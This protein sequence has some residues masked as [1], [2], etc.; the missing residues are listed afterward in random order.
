MEALVKTL[1]ELGS[2]RVMLVGD[3]MLDSWIYG[4]AERLSPEAPVPVL[5]KV[6]QETMTG[7]ASNIAPAITALGGEVVCVGVI[8][9]DPGGEELSSLLMSAGADASRLIR[10]SD[11]P[12]TVKTRYIGLAQHRHAQQ[13]FRLD[14]ESVEEFGPDVHEMLR[15][16]VR[17]EL[18][19]CE[20]LAIEDYNKGVLGHITTPQI[21]DEAR[22]AGVP[23]I[24]D[25]AL[26]SDYR[27][28][29]GANLLTPNR[30]EAALAS[31]I[32]ITDRE[33][34]LKAAERIAAITRAQAVVITL[35]AEGAFLYTVDGK[36]M[37][38]P[39]RARS[40]YDVSGA[41]DEVLA[42]LAVAIG[43]GCDLDIAV[44]LA[45]VAGGLEV[46]QF[47]IIPITRAQVIDELRKMIGLRTRKVI[48]RKVLA[49]EVSRRR[50]GGENI[51]FTNGC[52]DLLHVGHVRY[53]QQ[54]REQ[55]SCLV[56]AIN[57]DNS[58]RRLKG[59]DRPII[60]A[61]ERAEMLGALECVDYVTVF[62]EDTPEALLKLL[63]PEILIKGGSTPVVVGREIVEGY[64]G[65]VQTL[66][67]V[68]GMSTTNIIDR[69]VNGQG[70]A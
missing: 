52:F 19:S 32:E 29:A 25:P 26:I 37:V 53:L 16:A 14:E 44:G 8:G 33:S 15:A 43:D 59:P 60:G 35:D 12:T 28:Y 69:I 22:K 65:V 39:T 46:E 56:V 49:A 13:M 23:V 10:R 27:R 66:Q 18:H 24:V 17:S 50:K 45:N 47:G 38:I 3:F 55:G 34:M 9:D 36:S 62:D 48:E 6:R 41:G 54:A 58:V 51:V 11:R 42:M 68:D 61:D 57:S 20:I 4:H 63:K 21:I 64:G 40:V 5:R 7:G 30:F 2:P 67:L 1:G 70:N 31:G